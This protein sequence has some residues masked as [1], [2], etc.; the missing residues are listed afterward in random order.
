MSVHNRQQ[1]SYGWANLEWKQEA[2]DDSVACEDSTELYI[3]ITYQASTSEYIEYRLG[4]LVF[5][6]FSTQRTTGLL[7]GTLCCLQGNC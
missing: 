6:F 4:T 1:N 3:H 5:G 7:R 2:R